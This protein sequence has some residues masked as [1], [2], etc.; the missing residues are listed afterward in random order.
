MSKIV[1]LAGILVV[2]LAGGF[3]GAW[4]YAQQQRLPETTGMLSPQDYL[5]IQQ[6]YYLYSRDVDPGSRNNAA[7]LFTTDGVFDLGQTKYA[8]E[9]ALTE[10]Y[11]KN[12][13]QV[14][15]AGERHF[16]SNLVIVPTGGGAHTSSYMM[17]VERLDEGLPVQITLFGKYEDDVVK[18]PAGWRFKTRMWRSD[19][20]RKAKP[21]Q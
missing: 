17:Q 7:R 1:R 15:L 18:T 14:F 20:H 4:M 9:K 10:F 16:T 21:T 3:G 13:R 8:G 2:A 5:E 11:E 12:T 19:T 6:L